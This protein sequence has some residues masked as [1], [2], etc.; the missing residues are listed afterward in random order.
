MGIASSSFP[1]SSLSHTNN[2]SASSTLPPAQYIDIIPSG[3]TTEERDAQAFAQW[4]PPGLSNQ[5]AN[6]KR[7]LRFYKC[8]DSGEAYSA[9]FLTTK[10]HLLYQFTGYNLTWVNCEMGSFIM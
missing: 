3:S 5:H 1:S 9:S 6:D 8:M 10:E 4:P 7:Y 2:P